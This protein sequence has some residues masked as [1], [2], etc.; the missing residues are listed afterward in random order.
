MRRSDPA[1]K[2]IITSISLSNRVELRLGS[3]ESV[4]ENVAIEYVFE[5]NLAPPDK[6]WVL[7]RFR[8][9]AGVTFAVKI[10]GLI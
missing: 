3:S 9:E 6:N 10:H 5:S 7:D 1:A 4:G 2:S 8:N